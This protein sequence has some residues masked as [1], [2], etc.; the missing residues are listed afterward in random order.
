MAGPTAG[1]DTTLKAKRILKA[2]MQRRG[3]TY[4]D[5][6]EALRQ[7]GAGPAANEANIR[8]Q[9][10]RGGFGAGFFIECCLAMGSYVVRLGEP[11]QDE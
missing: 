11:G 2:E 6:A 7:R 10:N 9:I 1:N 4:K 8:N 5:L 3:F